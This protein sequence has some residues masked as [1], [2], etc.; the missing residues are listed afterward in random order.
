MGSPR[1]C[2]GATHTQT[3]GQARDHPSQPLSHDYHHGSRQS[4]GSQASLRGSSPLLV[5][6]LPPSPAYLPTY[7]CLRQV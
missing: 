2:R 7:L 4:A 6:G 5:N 3:D 1:I